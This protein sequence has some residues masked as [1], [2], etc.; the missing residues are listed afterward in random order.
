M[1]EDTYPWPHKDLL[2]VTGLSR[3]DVF[4]LLD[5]ARSFHEINR[6][7]VKK[8]PTLKGKTVVLFF[9]EPSTRTRVSFDTAGKRL[10]ADTF[11]LG[12]SGS[13]Q[14]KGETLKDTALT[15]Q[16][17]NPDVIVIRDSS[18]GAAQFLAERLRCP[19][20]NAGDGCHAHPTQALLDAYALRDAWHDKFE[21]KTLVILGDSAHGRVARSNVHLLT[22]LGVRVRLCGPRTLLPPGVEKWPVEVF[23]RVED[24]VQDADAVMC[25]RLQLERQQ[26]GLLPDL[27]DYSARYCLTPARLALARPGARVLHPGPLNRGLEISSELADSSASLILD[28]VAAGVAV[29]MAVLYLYATRSDAAVGA[30][31]PA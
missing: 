2:D 31:E 10:S 14:L 4:R 22:S 17:M 19:V 27:R 30:G 21:G 1:H 8:V 3:R 26:A 12:K 29:R 23:S 18:S 5:S 24:A 13:S 16:A 20:V 9:A 11:A 25:L 15:L 28:Q 6:R 7:P